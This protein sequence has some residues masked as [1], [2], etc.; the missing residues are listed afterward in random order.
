MLRAYLDNPN[1]R[2]KDINQFQKAAPIDFEDPQ[3]EL[4]PEAYLDQAEPSPASVFSTL[5]ASMRDAL[6][7]LIKTKGA[8]LRSDLLGAAG[9]QEFATPLWKKFAITDIFDLKR[10][11]FHSIANLDEGTYPT[12]SRVS[13]DNGF[14]GYYDKPARAVVWPARTI[15]VSTVTGDAFVQPTPFIATDNVVL[16]TLKTA[17]KGIKLSSLF[18]IQSMMNEIKW[19]YSY[20]RQCYKTKY[21]KTEIMLPVQ[22]NGALDENYMASMV[23]AANHWLL[24]EAGFGRQSI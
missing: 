20:G 24:V 21:A 4:V 6:A 23:E 16:C 9:T 22:E 18:F 11:S 15:T 3:L 10:G 1:L 17:Y 19:R 2:V 5:E 12:I 7:Y 13:T 8:V 14:V